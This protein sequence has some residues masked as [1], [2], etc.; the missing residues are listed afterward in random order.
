MKEVVYSP[1]HAPGELRGLRWDHDG[2][3]GV[4][5]KHDSVPWAV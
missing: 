4:I 5:H 2:L 1:P 3:K